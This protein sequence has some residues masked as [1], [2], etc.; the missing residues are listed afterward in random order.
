[1]NKGIVLMG[2]LLCGLGVS[3]EA[4]TTTG[5]AAVNCEL[6]YTRLE[7]LPDAL[8]YLREDEQLSVIERKSSLDGFLAKWIKDH[9]FYPEEA[10]RNGITGDAVATLLVKEDG[11]VCVAKVSATDPIF[12]AAT[13]RM[14]EGFPRLMP[15]IKGEKPWIFT[16]KTAP[17]VFRPQTYIIHTKGGG[18]TTTTIQKGRGLKKK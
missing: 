14:F 16:Y 7:E 5:R 18:T 2:L 10:E 8:P 15:A 4:Q 13:R 3:A 9:Y 17:I 11:V 1:M 6:D 12:D